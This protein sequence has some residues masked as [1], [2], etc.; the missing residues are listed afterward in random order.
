MRKRRKGNY[1]PCSHMATN[2]TTFQ[3]KKI[4]SKLQISSFKNVGNSVLNT[5]I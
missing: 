4:T 5:I 2:P 1:P 3:E